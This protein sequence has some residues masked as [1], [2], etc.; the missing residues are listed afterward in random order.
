MPVLTA[1]L[2]LIGAVL[3]AGPASAHATL[4]GTDPTEGQV[5]ASAPPS[6]TFSFDE[7]VRSSDGGVRLFDAAGKELDADASTT[8]TKLKVELPG[9]LADG[10]YVVAWRVVSSDGHPIAGALTFS[11]GAPSEKVAA[12]TAV[13]QASPTSVRAALGTAQGLTY[14]GI[15]GAGGLVVFA[16]LLLPRDNGID[17]IRERLL[18]VAR[19]FA[20]LVVAAGFS[21]VVVTT[22]Y[23]R[24]EGFSALFSDSPVDIPTG[25]ELVSWAVAAAGVWVGVLAG[26]RTGDGARVVA[27]VGVVAALGALG[28]VGHTRA[29]PPL[30]L[31][32][33]TDLVHVAAGA[34]WFGGL[35]G[36]VISLRRLADRPRLAAQALGRFSALAGWLLLGVAVT[37]TLLGWRILRDWDNVLT[38]NFGRV[39]LVKIGVVAVVA[40]IAG[41]NRYRLMPAVLADSGFAARGAAAARMR[42]TVRVE[43]VLL[44]GVLG[45]TGF[46][47]DRSPVQ[48]S[49]SVALPGGLDSSTYTGQFGKVKVVAVI[50]P[51]KVGK[52]TVLL[53][54]QD[55]SGNPLEPL[56]TPALSVTDGA[57]ALGDQAVTNVDSGTYRATVLIPKAAT[58]TI[59]V[60]VP[61]SEFDSP[62]VSVEVPVLS[63]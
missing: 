37:G 49:G 51:A 48:D 19:W 45:L 61:L 29:F 16:L 27:L 7:P 62:V 43:A 6:V 17:Q 11:I 4:I 2:A 25:A 56:G 59:Q 35:L 38:T 46:L 18:R 20:W 32:L 47:V 12:T 5:L 57:L 1:L 34:V 3:T 10:T 30:W 60:S 14:L 28:L 53:Q 33:S 54:L 52:N 15:F 8:D 41:W 42:R 58:W 39:L 13:P 55:L 9:A 44:V 24:A 31:M 22:L 50:E 26:R 40:A 21:A 23:Q 63:R 36:L